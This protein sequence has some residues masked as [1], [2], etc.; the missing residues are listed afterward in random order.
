MHIP[1]ITD[2]LLNRAQ[3]IRLAV[4]DVDG[5]LTDGR[6]HFLPD[7]SEIK[8]FNSQDGLGLQM[9]REAGITTAIISG[10]GGSALEKRAKSLGIAH[11]Y[12]HC[13]NKLAALNE[14]CQQHQLDLKQ[15]AHLGDDL[16]D[17]PLIRRVGLGMVVANGNA[18]VRGQAHAVTVARGG[19]GAAREFCE[20]ILHAQGKLAAIRA[21]WL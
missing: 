20:L 1:Y 14:L 18:F 16:P 15:V 11:L 7:G 10:R 4:F 3:Q 13:H 17:L 2:E 8:V 21:A 5:V 6:L 9:L 12:Q 19:E